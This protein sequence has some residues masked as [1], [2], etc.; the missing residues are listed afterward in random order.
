MTFLTNPVVLTTPSQPGTP[1]A[2]TARGSQPRRARGRIVTIMVVASSCLPMAGRAQSTD[3]RAERVAHS[4]SR[5]PQSGNATPRYTIE[6]EMERLHVTG[7]SVAIVAEGKVIW[8]K[9]F[10]TKQFGRP[11]PVD[12]TTLFLAGSISKPVFATGALALVERG[13]VSLDSDINTSLKS[14]QLPVSPFTQTEKVTLRRILSHTA[15]L[16]VWGF[17]GYEVGKPLPT[18]PQILDGIAPANTVAVRNDATPG[19]RWLYSGGGMTIAQLAVTDAAGES[20]PVLMKRLVFEP[21]GMKRSTYENPIPPSRASETASGHEPADTVVTGRWHV[22]PEMAAAGL[23]TT[24]T[25][26]ALWGV[27]LMK[28][29]RGEAGGVLS[30]TMAREMLT[31]QTALAS[32]GPAPE[33]RQVRGVPPG[34]LWGLGVAVVGTGRD[35][36]FAHG[37]RDEGFIGGVNRPGFLGGLV[38]R[39]DQ[40][41]GPTE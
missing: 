18:V 14:W 17:P 27:S 39:E 40:A 5:Q 10:G 29:Y 1:E 6:Q 33:R 8:A 36:Q 35:F 11:E 31:P 13:V 26:L 23:W 32:T 24:P 2:V 20:F 28:S 22:Y 30:P 19:A 41:H 3:A 21:L 34:S 25:D 15:G 4:L 16:T 9:G 38:S 7:A 37:G 12:T